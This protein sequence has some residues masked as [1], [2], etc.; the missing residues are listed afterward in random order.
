MHEN[1]NEKRDEN[2]ERGGKGFLAD[3]GFEEI[4]KC[5]NE[6]L[7]DS[8]AA[9]REKLGFADHPKDKRDNERGDH[10]ARD[11]AVGK[12]P[13]VTEIN[14]LSRRRRNT[15]AFAR[16]RGG[17]REQGGGESKEFFEVR[18]DGRKVFPRRGKAHLLG[19]GVGVRQPSKP[20]PF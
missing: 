16:K 2:R 10:P 3:D 1:K 15:A 8:L 7:D 11:H 4:A 12:S 9:R 5:G 13:A 20:N 6:R 18:H 14:E 19:G 17:R